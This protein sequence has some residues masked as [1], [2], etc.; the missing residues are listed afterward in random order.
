[1]EQVTKMRSLAARASI[2]PWKVL[3]PDHD[4]N[5]PHPPHHHHDYHDFHLLKAFVA[6][7]KCRL[8]TCCP[9]CPNCQPAQLCRCWRWYL[10]DE[11][12]ENPK[13]DAKNA[14]ESGPD[15]DGG[16]DY[17]VDEITRAIQ[18][19]STTHSNVSKATASWEIIK[20]LKLALEKHLKR[21]WKQSHGTKGDLAWLNL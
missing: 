15:Q 8:P 5:H 7:R 6:C 4:D 2:R 14:Y 1:M 9:K 10:E 17:C 20:L 18:S 3:P 11:E 16:G 19:P 13:L 12:D 21:V